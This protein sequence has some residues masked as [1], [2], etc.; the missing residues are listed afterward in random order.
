MSIK[1]RIRNYNSVHWLNKKS[2]WGYVRVI[3]NWLGNYK[4]VKNKIMRNHV[5]WILF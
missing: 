1:Y 3:N 2:Y 5:D 4:N